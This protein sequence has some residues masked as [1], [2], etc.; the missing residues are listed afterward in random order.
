MDLC[1]GCGAAE[2]CYNASCIDLAPAH[3]SCMG[4]DVKC[5]DLWYAIAL[6]MVW[7]AGSTVIMI[8]GRQ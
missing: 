3:D 2:Y 7:A 8:L 6:T 5:S 4:A 1:G